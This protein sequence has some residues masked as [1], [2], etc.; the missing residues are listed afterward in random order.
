MNDAL[1]H[2]PGTK[3]SYSSFGYAVLGAVV[4]AVTGE[5]FGDHMQRTLFG[6]LGMTATCPEIHEELIP[7][8]SRYYSMWTG[9]L[10]NSAYVDNYWKLP[11]DGFLSSARDLAGFGAACLSPHV[12]PE[13]REVL[14]KPTRLK[15]GTLVDYGFGW[16]IFKAREGS[17]DW[18]VGHGGDAVGATSYLLVQPERNLVLALVCNL[19]KAIILPTATTLLRL[20]AG[21]D[22]SGAGA[23]SP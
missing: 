13:M 3:F 18:T 17:A 22:P 4:E 7:H 23:E 21:D 12:P 16:K 15:D 1:E 19:S 6:P 8:R 10:R 11:G 14:W 5:H 9:A 2:A 20:F